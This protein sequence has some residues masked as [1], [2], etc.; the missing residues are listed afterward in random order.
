MHP[1]Q[2]L[3]LFVLPMLSAYRLMG[4]GL[5]TACDAAEDSL[6]G[7]RPRDEHRLWR[8][9]SQSPLPTAEILPFPSGRGSARQRPFRPVPTG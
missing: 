6:R 8:P 2:F 7:C 4:Q 3:A 1:A 9:M 5:V